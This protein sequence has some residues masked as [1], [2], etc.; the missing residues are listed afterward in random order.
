MYLAPLL[1]QVSYMYINELYRLL[2]KYITEL[3]IGL[4][5]HQIVQRMPK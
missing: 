4:L 5:L 1:S 2:F 3:N